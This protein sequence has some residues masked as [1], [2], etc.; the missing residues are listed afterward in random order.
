MLEQTSFEK[1]KNVPEIY[2]TFL[3]SVIFIS[4]FHVIY[5]DRDQNMNKVPFFGMLKIS[6]EPLQGDEGSQNSSYE[7][8]TYI[9]AENGTHYCSI[10]EKA[11]FIPNTVN[12]QTTLSLVGNFVESWVLVSFI[13]FLK[14]LV[15][16]SII[17]LK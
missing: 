16:T 2:Q 12:M 10:F 6:V 9:Q 17:F 13:I 14:Y 7:I 5:M 1:P 4:Y 8:I 11:C 3:L 15:K